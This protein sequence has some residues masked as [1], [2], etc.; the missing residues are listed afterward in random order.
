MRTQVATPHLLQAV[1]TG[2]VL[3]TAILT[4]RKAGGQQQEYMI[5]TISNA[6]LVSVKIGC[7][8]GDDLVARDE[9]SMAFKKIQLDY[10]EQKPDGTLGGAVSFLDD[11]STLT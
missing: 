1:S 10:K 6:M 11:W 8:V 2:E 9:V 4:C 7:L 5:W 3:K